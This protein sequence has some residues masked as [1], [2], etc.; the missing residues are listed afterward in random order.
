MSF[1]S[2]STGDSVTMRKPHPCGSYEWSVTRTGADIGL[3]CS[4]CGRRV[5]LTR[6]DFERR[7]KK[8]TSSNNEAA[9]LSTG[10]TRETS[11]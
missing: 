6:D 1:V 11:C 8:V 7:V 2:V 5:M 10:S 9:V 3:Q 4:T